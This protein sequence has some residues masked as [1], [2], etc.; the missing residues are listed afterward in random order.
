MFGSTST[1]GMPAARSSRGDGLA[2]GQRGPRP[3]QGRAL[4]RAGRPHVGDG[5]P[6]QRRR[7]PARAR[8]TQRVMGTRP[9]AGQSAPRL[10]RVDQKQ[11]GQWSRTVTATRAARRPARQPSAESECWAWTTSAVALVQ[12]ARRRR[13]ARPGACARARAAGARAGRPRSSRARAGGQHGDVVAGRAQAQGQRAGG[14]ARPRP[15]AAG[16]PRW[17]GRSS[18]DAGIRARARASSSLGSARAQE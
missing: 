7:A 13:A 4:L 3:A 12:G 17:P 1:R 2:H 16:R 10:M 14:P 18:R 15:R 9:Q 6:G 8:C 11:T 5:G